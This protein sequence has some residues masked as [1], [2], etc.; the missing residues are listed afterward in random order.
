[1][2]D[3]KAGIDSE[4]RIR[5]DRLHSG[6]NQALQFPANS[7]DMAPNALQRL[8]EDLSK[9]VSEDL[10]K[11]ERISIVQKVEAELC[12]YHPPALLAADRIRLEDRLYRLRS[13]PRAEWKKTLSEFKRDDPCV[14][15][16][17]LLHRLS[18]ELA[19]AAESFQRLAGIRSRTLFLLMGFSLIVTLLILVLFFMSL[20]QVVKAAQGTNDLAMFVRS[21]PEPLMYTL[22]LAGSMGAIITT[23][24][25]VIHENKIRPDYIWTLISNILIRIA[26]GAVY[27]I[28]VVFA[29]LSGLLPLSPSTDEGL[30]LFLIV[31]S[32][33][34][35]LSDKFFGQAISSVISGNN[36]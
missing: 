34:A 16:R 36:R 11:E 2:T 22:S 8:K 28:V 32:I 13:N 4:F 12:L 15:H 20:V 3:A 33:A 18:F 19:E 5:I 1:M 6:I 31:A 9:A 30:I 10:P 21:F 35:G 27:A 25:A 24:D 14:E 26:F 7:N 23:V 29:L 17:Q